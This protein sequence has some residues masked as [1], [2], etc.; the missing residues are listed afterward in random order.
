ML[1]RAIRPAGSPVTS[2][3]SA[4]SWFVRVFA[5]C[6]MAL[7]GCAGSQTKGECPKKQLMSLTFDTH[8]ELNHDRDGYSRSVVVRV[9]QLDDIA[10]F[11]QVGFDALWA[12]GDLPG[13]VAGPDELTL[14]PGRKQTESVPRRDKAA[15][16][17]IAANFRE[18]DSDSSWK[19]LVQLPPPYDPCGDEEEVSP[20]K[21]SMSLAN[22]TMRVR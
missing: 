10:A 1:R 7:A 18:Q 4:E 14:V 2:F 21:L 22:Y 20:F 17:A 13:A 6:V 3:I 9:Y 15:Y 5:L 11:E 8:T 12:G 19:T 16:L